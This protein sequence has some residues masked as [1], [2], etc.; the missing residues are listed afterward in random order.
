[1][2][3]RIARCVFSSDYRGHGT[4]CCV[5]HAITGKDKKKLNSRSSPET[6]F[7]PLGDVLFKIIIVKS[8]QFVILIVVSS[9]GKSTEVRESDIKMDWT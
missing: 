2:E 8:G 4:V 3:S 9:R 1:M 7:V 6:S 5:S